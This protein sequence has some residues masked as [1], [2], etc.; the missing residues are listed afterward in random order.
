MWML[1][2]ADEVI[3]ARHQVSGSEATSLAP[4]LLTLSR[5]E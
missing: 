1:A 3:D 2:R 5:A 4:H